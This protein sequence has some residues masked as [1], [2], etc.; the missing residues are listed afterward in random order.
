MILLEMD[1]WPALRDRVEISLDWQ[2]LH[3][4]LS[5]K[6]LELL[7]E[8]IPKLSRVAVLGSSTQPG[9]VQTLRE[10]ELAADA[11]KVK[12]QYVDVL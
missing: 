9:N 12:I 11:L 6:Q 7:K 4:E 10:I 1:S 8:I 2:P 5:G 3:R